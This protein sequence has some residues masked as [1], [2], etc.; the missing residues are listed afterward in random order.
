MVPEVK[1]EFCNGCSKCLEVCPV[2]A[3]D[4]SCGYARI[5]EE[6]CEECGVCATYC[7]AGAI[8]INF[9]IRGS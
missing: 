7:P 2:D 8:R 6:F 9:P 4:L 5:E 1:K 3:I